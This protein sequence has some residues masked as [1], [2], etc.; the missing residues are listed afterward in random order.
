MDTSRNV[1]GE[2]Q[3]VANFTV[4]QRRGLGVSVGEPRYVLELDPHT[5]TVVI[6]S[7]RELA[8]ESIEVERVSWVSG[9]PPVGSH[10][11]VQIRAHGEPVGAKLGS[12]K[13]E[14]DR[15][16]VTFTDAEPGAAPG[17]AA[18]F[19]RDDE[20]LGGGTIARLVR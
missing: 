20:V 19:Y 8:T 10:C 18:V 4:G 3:G 11:E 13:A 2:H 12:Y 6:G 16:T 9:A 5:S 7:A 1:L 15:W 17:Q 14:S